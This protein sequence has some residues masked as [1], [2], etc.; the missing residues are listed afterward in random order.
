MVLLGLIKGIE[1]TRAEVAGELMKSD[2]ADVAL[3]GLVN[4]LKCKRVENEEREKENETNETYEV[5]EAKWKKTDSYNK[6][7]TDGRLARW[8][9]VKTPIHLR[10]HPPMLF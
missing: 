6:I 8:S 3:G 5:E 4:F 1:V 2:D 9:V 7:V 10:M